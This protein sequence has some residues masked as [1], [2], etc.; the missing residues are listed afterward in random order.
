MDLPISF[1]ALLLLLKGSLLHVMGSP[2]QAQQCLQQV[3]TL[4]KQ[5]QDDTHLVPY[6]LVELAV[7]AKNQGENDQAVQLIESARKNY[8]GYS[9]ESRLHFR[10]HSLMLDLGAQKK[11]SEMEDSL[12]NG[13]EEENGF[14]DT[15][16]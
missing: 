13:D 3:I 1:R 16:L 9:L 11:V 8:T 14:Y 7:I 5:I 6:A 2:L 15:R 12:G 10:M 4:E